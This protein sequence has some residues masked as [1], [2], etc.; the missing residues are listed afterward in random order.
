MDVFDTHIHSEGRSVEDLERMAKEGIKKAVTCAFY[1][2]E[3]KFPETMI[4]LFRKLTTFEVER[5]KS[6]G[7]ELYPAIGI[8]PR[9]IPPN[10]GR[11]V[12]SMEEMECVAFGEIGL[13][14]ATD[15]EVEVFKEQLKLAKRLDKPCIIHTPRR[16]KVEVTE[17]TL[18]ILQEIGFPESLAVIDH[19]TNDTVKV[20]LNAG[21]Y[22]G[23]TVQVGKLNAEEV[24]EIVSEFGF[25][26]F[27]LNSD[28]G[29]DKAD[30]FATAKAV[31][32]LEEKGIDKSDIEK[33]AVKNALRLFKL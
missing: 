8:H 32:F 22:V 20:I 1:P 19:A 13:E 11:A 17:K 10:Y 12:E 6:A 3:P 16:N 5:G 4:D 33:L 30:M 7:M 18:K 28:T 25:E 27:V 31:R 21:Y 24:Y 26:R 23:L 14:T 29:F 2:I 15:L 9:C